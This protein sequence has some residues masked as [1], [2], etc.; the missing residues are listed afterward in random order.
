MSSPHETGSVPNAAELA[1]RMAIYDVLVRHSRGVDRADSAILASAY[2]ADAEVAY[3]AFN[4]AAQTF[5]ERL[6]RMMRGFRWTQHTIGNVAIDLHGADAR[7]E[8]YVTARHY[9]A[10]ASGSDREMT[11]FGRYL[12]RML[13]RG[14]VWKIVH[15]RVLMDWNQNAPASANWQGPPF[16]GLARGT[17]DAHDPLYA[18]LAS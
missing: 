7:V 12:D 16:D 6:P 5:C 4:G 13:R 14:D 11:V 1:D 9:I 18:H 10:D 2:W 15:R 3:G 17:R 8:T